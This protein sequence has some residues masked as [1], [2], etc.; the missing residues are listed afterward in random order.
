MKALQWTT[1][2][3]V[4]VVMEMGSVRMEN[5]MRVLKL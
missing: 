4:D 3:K 1:K 5:Q 2:V